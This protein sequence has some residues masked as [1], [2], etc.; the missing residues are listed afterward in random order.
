MF[1]TGAL[2]TAALHL[3]LISLH[4]CV[5]IVR[6][7]QDKMVLRRIAIVCCLFAW[8]SPPALLFLLALIRPGQ[9]LWHC[10]RVDF[11]YERQF[12][13]AISGFLFALFLAISIC[14]IRLVS[15]AN[16]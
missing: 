13:W 11:Y 12:R 15:F 16:K 4:H 6:P 7:H 2:L 14:Y 10:E 1:R 8:C 9:G 5:G 3:L